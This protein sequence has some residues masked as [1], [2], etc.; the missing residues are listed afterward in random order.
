MARIAG[1]S[2]VSGNIYVTERQR[3]GRVWYLRARLGDGREV[4]RR[5]GPDWS[6]SGR[7]AAGHYTRKTAQAVLDEL[8]VEAR[9][10]TLPIREKSGATFADAAA[11]W[12]RYAEHERGVKP[13]TLRDYRTSVRAYLLPAFGHLALE[14]VTPDRIDLWR[15]RLLAERRLSRRTAEGDDQPPR[16]F[17]RAKRVWR[18]PANPVDD[19]ERVQAP[20]RGRST[21]SVP[22][23]SGPSFARRRRSRTPR[24]S[25]QQRSRAQPGE[26]VALRW[27]S[28]DFVNAAVRVIESYSPH[29]ALTTPKSRRARVPPLV[30]DVAQALA[31]LAHR[32]LFAGPDDLVFPSD[33]GEFQDGSAVRKRFIRARDRAGLRPLRFHDLRHTFGSLEVRTGTIVEVQAWMGH[34]SPTVTARYLHHRPRHDEAARLGKAFGRGSP[35]HDL[36]RRSLR[37]P[38]RE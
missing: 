9:R 2:L 4:R 6:G 5:I 18:L 32:E 10:G 26:L 33:L 12:L 13:S 14:D 23:R 1:P 21:S 8:L 37:E 17:A 29:G 16:I 28:V 19:V 11:E 15:S 25:S 7:P 27:R 3:A 35:E 38:P 36:G 31:Q 22:R 34:S 24:C 20:T 30:D